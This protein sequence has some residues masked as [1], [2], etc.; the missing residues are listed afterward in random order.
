MLVCGY[1][2][3]RRVACTGPYP[4]GVLVGGGVGLLQGE[5]VLRF[6]LEA[7]AR[8]ERFFELFDTLRAGKKE[9]AIGLGL[10]E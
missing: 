5:Q 4:E 3:A 10:Q 7:C 6:V 2:S 1:S 9:T 8:R